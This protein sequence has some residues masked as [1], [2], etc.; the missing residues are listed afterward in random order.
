MTSSHWWFLHLYHQPR[1]LTRTV[2]PTG[3]WA[4]WPHGWMLWPQAQYNQNWSYCILTLLP[5]LQVTLYHMPFTEVKSKE[6]ILDA[7]VSMIA[8]S[9]SLIIPHADKSCLT[10]D[11]TLSQ[12]RPLSLLPGPRRCYTLCLQSYSHLYCPFDGISNPGIRSCFTSA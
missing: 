1:F 7:S 2:H 4:Q 9:S 3:D 8:F 6:V 10:N 12:S 11:H 5:H